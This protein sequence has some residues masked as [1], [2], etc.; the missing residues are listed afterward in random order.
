MEL[1]CGEKKFGEMKVMRGKKVGIGRLGENHVKV[2]KMGRSNGGE[3]KKVG[4]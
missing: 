1:L 4:R 3:V 2:E